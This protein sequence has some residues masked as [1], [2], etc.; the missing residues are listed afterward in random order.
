MIPLIATPADRPPAR[1]SGAVPRPSRAT[2]RPS[3][4]IARFSAAH[5][6]RVQLDERQKQL[7]IGAAVLAV[8]LVVFALARGGSPA[9]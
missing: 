3:G 1:S 6:P 8:I 5:E 4:S 9:R 2:P 7:A